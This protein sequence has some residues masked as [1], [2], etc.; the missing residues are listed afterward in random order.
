MSEH[1][2]NSQAVSRRGRNLNR[3]FV[4]ILALEAL[5]L[6]VA[7]T[8]LVYELV[9]EQPSSIASALALTVLTAIAAVAL[10]AAAWG[11]HTLRPLARG[12][13]MTWQILQIALALGSFQGLY[14]QPSIGFALLIPA[15]VAIALI[16]TP[17]VRELYGAVEKD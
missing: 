6:W 7:F 4:L 16:V 12:I 14:A 15:I 8:W 5:A 9:V 1:F 10:S 11:A 13:A 17:S 2:G 3:A